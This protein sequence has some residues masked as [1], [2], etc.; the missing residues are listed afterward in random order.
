MFQYFVDRNS[1][2]YP[3]GTNNSES[4]WDQ[5][6]YHISIIITF[7]V[8]MSNNVQQNTAERT[9]CTTLEGIYESLRE[10]LTEITLQVEAEAHCMGKH[11]T[12]QTER[13]R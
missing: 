12:F 11:S 8:F 4:I 2:P 9:L 1:W 6:E 7:L 5:L 10:L 13:P 3:N